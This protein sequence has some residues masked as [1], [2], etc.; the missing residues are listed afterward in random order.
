MK[1]TSY[2]EERTAHTYHVTSLLLK[3]IKQRLIDVTSFSL[4]NS[5][6]SRSVP[7]E[8]TINFGSVFTNR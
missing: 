6:Y 8:R 4:S 7:F 3:P 5:P 2:H 1:N